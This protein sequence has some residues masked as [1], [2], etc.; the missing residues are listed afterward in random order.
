MKKIIKNDFWFGVLMTL[1]VFACVT[2]FRNAQLLR[3]STVMGGEVFMLVL[4]LALLKMKI[5]TEEQK[6][7][8]NMTVKQ[9]RK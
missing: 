9:L 1:C 5:K 6:Q 4:P 8:Q 7:R 3:N 2:C